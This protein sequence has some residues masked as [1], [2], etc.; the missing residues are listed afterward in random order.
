[1]SEP[2]DPYDTLSAKLAEDDIRCRFQTSHQLT[3]SRQVGPVWPNA[4][5]SFWVTHATHTWHLFTW[6]PIGYRVP[7]EEDIAELCRACMAHG[8]QAM[9]SV[10]D[11]I[12]RQYKLERLSEEEENA[13]YRAMGLRD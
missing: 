10:P 1:M 5:N 3:V 7:E 12:A 2:S 13:V 4:G 9:H 8:D 6:S 11:E